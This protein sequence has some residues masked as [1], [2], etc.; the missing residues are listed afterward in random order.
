MKSA[1][2]YIFFTSNPEQI[3]VPIL[4]S[5]ASIRASS[6]NNI[7]VLDYSKTNWKHW[8]EYL[9]F[10]T[11]DAK[12][13]FKPQSSFPLN[14]YM[15]AKPLELLHYSAQVPEENV[16]Y[17]D[18][19][20]FWVKNPEPLIGDLDKLCSSWNTGLLY[21]NKNSR[22]VHRAIEMWKAYTYYALND[23]EFFNKLFD[24]F[25]YEYKFLHEEIIFRYIQTELVELGLSQDIK[26]YE[27]CSVNIT[28][29]IQPYKNT[30]KV[31]ALHIRTANKNLA[32]YDVKEIYDRIKSVD[33]QNLLIKDKSPTKHLPKIFSLT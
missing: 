30:T 26:D 31:K 21:F 28:D 14:P 27:N 10:Q 3:T 13:S 4:E 8:K 29:Y 18:A 9:G 7:Y 33:T 24:C 1:F 2:F 22:K 19:D 12:L 11:I 20:L 16:I 5:I 32:C 6:K 23:K 25:S 15:L 17:C